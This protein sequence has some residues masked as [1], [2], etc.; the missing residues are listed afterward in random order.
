[1]PQRTYMVVDE[2]R[3]HS[4]RVPRPDLSTATGVP[5]ACQNCHAENDAEWA[6]SALTKW[7]GP[8]SRPQFATALYA[9]RHGA[10]NE[11]LLAAYDNSATPG[12][13]R[14]TALELL[15][16][17]IG[18]EEV[19]A[20]SAGLTDA[21]PLVR[22]AAVRLLRSAPLEYRLQNGL[23]TLADTVR[24]VRLDSALAYADI[25]ESL[26]SA[27]RANFAKAAAEYR[28]A[29][30]M[31]L[32]RPDAWVSLGD[33]EIAS[34]NFDTGVANYERALAM[35]PMHLRARINLVDAMRAAGDDA[36][37]RRLLEQGLEMA[38]DNAA[39]HYALGLLFV[40]AGDQQQA[41]RELRDAARLEPGNGQ[42]RYVLDIALSEF[43]E[44]VED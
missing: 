19:A 3:D 31:I 40:R 28:A 4:F 11:L 26:P 23:Q 42:Y 12:I 6:S 8:S 39:L 13:A 17:P 27:A 37:G 25:H 34:G 33:F 15:S 7:H 32:D 44:T 9:G 35:E 38:P 18:A 10:G 5:N 14:A 20:L 1:M 24:S 36:R 2:R 16:P 21:D 22:I 43:G 29:Q 41:L 30:E